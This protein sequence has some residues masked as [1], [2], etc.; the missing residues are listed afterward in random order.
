M[1]RAVLSKPKLEELCLLYVQQYPRWASIQAIKLKRPEQPDGPN[2]MVA[3]MQP[4]QTL[5]TDLSVR[6]AIRELQETV[7][8]TT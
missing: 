6:L 7:R 4:S 5:T 3:E 8:M 2:W 1:I